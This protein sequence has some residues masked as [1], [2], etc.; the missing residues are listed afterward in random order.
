MVTIVGLASV[1]VVVLSLVLAW[2]AI[3][4]LRNPRSTAKE[5][6]Q[7]GLPRSAG[8]LVPIAEAV[9][10]LTLI[11]LPSWGSIFAFFLL[12]AFTSILVT[13]IRSGSGQP[14]SCFGQASSG[15]VTKFDLARNAVLLLFSVFGSTID[16]LQTPRPADVVIVGLIGVGLLG[17]SLVS[18]KVQSSFG[19][20][21]SGHDG[22]KG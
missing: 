5:F 3:A 21:N 8:R 2:A 18:K 7:L 13:I 19:V 20:A 10:A 9:V 6:Q 4:K 17:F 22:Y 14:C 12:A 15:P 11:A 1:A 16:R